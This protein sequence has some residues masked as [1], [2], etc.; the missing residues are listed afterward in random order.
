MSAD[1]LKDLLQPY[2]STVCTVFLSTLTCVSTCASIQ[3]NRTH[4]ELQK[5]FSQRQNLGPAALDRSAAPP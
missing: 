2:D 1:F 5:P 3:E 4:P